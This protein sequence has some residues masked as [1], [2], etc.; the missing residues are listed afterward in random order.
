MTATLTVVPGEILNVFVGGQGGAGR[1]GRCGWRL[2]WRRRQAAQ[3]IS[4]GGGGGAS[5][6][7]RGGNALSN[8]VVVAGGGGGGAFRSGG[9][10]AGG[11]T[12][13]GAGAN[14]S[15]QWA[16]VTGGGGGTQSAGGS[17]GM[18]PVD[19]SPATVSPGLPAPAARAVPRPSGASGGGGG[20]GYF[21]GGGGAGGDSSTL[22]AAAGGGGSSFARPGVV[23][24]EASHTGNGAVAILA[25]ARSSDARCSEERSDVSTTVSHHA[26]GATGRRSVGLRLGARAGA[27]PQ[28]DRGVRVATV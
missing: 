23:H 4:D 9:G 18:N 15:R 24:A 14:S 7:R 25:T 8:R 27:C 3:G 20:G 21:G 11:G 10:G 17:G 19:P 16:T 28:P 22:G 26:H 5:D 6:I 12:T 1:R 13:G 2:Q